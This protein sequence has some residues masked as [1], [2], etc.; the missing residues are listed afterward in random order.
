VQVVVVGHTRELVNQT[1]DVY[2][3]LVQYDPR[4]KICNLLDGPPKGA[5]VIVT[6]LGK[7]L[8]EIFAKKPIDLNSLKVFILDEADD[9]FMD[10]KRE[11]EINRWH[12]Y[13]T[14]QLQ[15]VQIILFS[16]TFDQD[17]AEKISK[18]VSNANQI[19]LKQEALK[20]DNI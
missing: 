16:A 11:E 19:S 14:T 8:R 1:F 5:Q 4:Y 7:I 13:V 12:E 17:I 6:T 18:I 2:N 20:L 9:F 3:K 15:N 10:Q